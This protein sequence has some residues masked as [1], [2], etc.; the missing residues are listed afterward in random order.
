M[1]G[2][3]RPKFWG[4]AFYPRPF[5]AGPPNRVTLTPHYICSVFR[6][7]ILNFAT[8]NFIF[9]L[10][11]ILP[12]V[13]PDLP[14]FFEFSLPPIT[15]VAFSIH[16]L[17]YLPSIFIFFEYFF[18]ILPEMRSDFTWNLLSNCSRGG[19]TPP[20]PPRSLRPCTGL[21]FISVGNKTC[22]L[23]LNFLNRWNVLLY[24]GIPCSSCIIQ[25]PS[26]KSPVQPSLDVSG[27]VIE[28]PSQEVQDTCGFSSGIVRLAVPVR[29][30]LNIY[31]KVP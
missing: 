24:V 10:L 27:T 29:V 8:V 25:V 7:L 12:E 22:C 31:A 26:N 5:F 6:S 30:V 11:P 3:V 18:A 2:R 28:I 20:T 13:R 16:F 4:M 21:L 15:S 23:S 17:G 19:V 14:Q 1:R 9:F